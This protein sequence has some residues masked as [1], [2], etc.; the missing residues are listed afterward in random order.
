MDS[1]GAFLA[2]CVT[3]CTVLAVTEPLY[4]ASELS[5]TV[6]SAAGTPVQDAIIIAEPVKGSPP[7][8][9]GLKGIMDQRNLMFVP[10]AM[11]MQTRTQV[12]FPNSVHVRHQV[13]SFSPANTFQL[14]LYAVM[15]H[16]AVLFYNPELV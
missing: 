1:R 10:G 2:A 15:A 9:P 4:A 5:I 6:L 3:A 12:D 7:P 11:V 13:S 8:R 16:A 14:P